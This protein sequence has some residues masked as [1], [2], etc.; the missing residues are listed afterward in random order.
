VSAAAAGKGHLGALAWLHSRGCPWDS[1]TCSA[2]AAGGHLEVLR[3][4]HERGCPLDFGESMRSCRGH[5]NDD[6]VAYLLA[7]GGQLHGD[8]GYYDSDDY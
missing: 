1:K 5:A 7:E 4:A 8:V 2:A 3:Y 6:V